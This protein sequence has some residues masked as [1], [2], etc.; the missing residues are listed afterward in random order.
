MIS[1]D[2]SYNKFN[3]WKG[4][5]VNAFQTINKIS[6]HCYLFHKKVISICTQTLLSWCKIQMTLV[7]HVIAEN[8]FMVNFNCSSINLF[9]WHK[10]NLCCISCSYFINLLLILFNIGLFSVWCTPKVAAGGRICWRKK[11]IS[12]LKNGTSSSF[13][14]ISNS[15]I[16][17]TV[18]LHE[19]LGFFSLFKSLYI[20]T[21][22]ILPNLIIWPEKLV[23]WTKV[24]S[25][26]PAKQCHIR[27]TS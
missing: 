24:S 6:Y 1:L 19:L 3:F 25:E 4:N 14:H 22:Y 21:L 11:W 7:V 17:A 12:L 27:K 20:Y 18:T 5:M 13:S 16:I 15:S 8:F 23:I 10:F 9:R 26:N 2:A